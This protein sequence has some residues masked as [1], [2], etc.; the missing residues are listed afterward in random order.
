MIIHYEDGTF[1]TLHLGDLDASCKRNDICWLRYGDGGD[2]YR[3]PFKS[4]CETKDY[5]LSKR[6]TNEINLGD[7]DL[8][9]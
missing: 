2:W 4:C 3:S 8:S 6:T 9:K 7:A 5:L 1:I